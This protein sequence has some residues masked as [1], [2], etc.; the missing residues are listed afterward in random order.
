GALAFAAIAAEFVALSYWISTQYPHALGAL[1]GTPVNAPRAV[2][3]ALD[4][5]WPLAAALPALAF[6]W[7]VIRERGWLPVALL[8]ASLMAQVSRL[9]HVAILL[10][11]AALVLARRNGKLP[12]GRLALYFAAC[13]L[14]TATQIF[15]LQANR[16]GTLSQIMGLLL[17]WPS[18]RVYIA[19]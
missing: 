6:S 13:V 12:V 5:V 9:D 7:Y 17:G 19:V 10:V 18:V 15:Y 8:A 1:A 16:A 4:V 11:V 3:P 14:L 2:A